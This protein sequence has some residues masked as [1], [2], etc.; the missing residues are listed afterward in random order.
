MNKIKASLASLAVASTAALASAPAISA[1]DRPLAY[2]AVDKGIWQVWLAKLDGS[3]PRVL[4]R[5]PYDKTEVSW[6][7]DGERLLING[8]AGEMA[9]VSAASGAERPFKLAFDHG[10]DASVSPDGL[11]IAFSAMNAGGPDT[12]DIWLAKPD[13]SEAKKIA[14]LPALQHEPVW[15][16]DGKT[17]YFLSGPGGQ[18]HDIYKVSVDGKSLEQ[19]TTAQLYHFDLSVAPDGSIAFS[20]NRS[21]NYDIWCRD[22]AGKERVIVGTLTFEA[23]PAWVPGK[24]SIVFTR[25]TEGIPN[26]WIVGADGQDARALTRHK[27]GARNAAFWRPAGDAK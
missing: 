6:F 27:Q 18:S 4:T 25:N 15:N 2:V 9:V 23:H 19:L 1:P 8:S 3:K 13:G 17:I 5:S 7:P 20:S 10:S 16:P 26:L 24:E 21:G 22:P 11:H 14:S 12:N